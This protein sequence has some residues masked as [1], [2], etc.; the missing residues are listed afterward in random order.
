MGFSWRLGEGILTTTNK[1]KLRKI[2]GYPLE[3]PKAT[4]SSQLGQKLDEYLGQDFTLIGFGIDATPLLESCTYD[5][6]RINIETLAI[7]KP[8]G[9][10]IK[11]GNLTK[12]AAT[13]DVKLA[14]IRPDR[15]IYGVCTSNQKQDIGPQLQNLITT[16]SSQLT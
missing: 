14:L 10:E 3:Q 4:L 7:G 8:Y 16:L 9:L 6:K 11:N 5:R 2:A 12:W 1:S 13:H 15:Q